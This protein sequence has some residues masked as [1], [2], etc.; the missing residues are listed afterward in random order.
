MAG[1]PASLLEILRLHREGTL[2]EIHKALPG[3]VTAYDAETNTA[4]VLP[5]IKQS[6]FARDRERTYEAFD[7]IPFVPIVFPRSGNNAMTFPVS[8]GDHVLLIFCDVGLAE[9]HESGDVSEPKDARRHSCG[10][11]VAI[12]GLYPDA[13]RL[14]SAAADLAARAAGPVFGEHNGNLRIELVKGATSADDRIKLGKDATEFVALANKVDAIVDAIANA[15]GPDIGAA[16][17]AAVA[18]AKT[19]NG[20]T[21]A[22]AKTKAK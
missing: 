16:I 9:W 15:T 18:A 2:D 6:L 19:A 13:E 3:K 21:V 7:E 4:F 8:E 5:L 10:W 22:A 14:S 1:R 11:P 12:P 20:G 17:K